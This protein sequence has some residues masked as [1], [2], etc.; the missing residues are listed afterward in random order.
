MKKKFNEIED[1]TFDYSIDKETNREVVKI[2]DSRTHEVIRQYPP[3]EILNM[4]KK[5][6]ELFGF[7]VDERF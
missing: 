4:V 2:M 7:F 1:I 3:E 6:N 5:M